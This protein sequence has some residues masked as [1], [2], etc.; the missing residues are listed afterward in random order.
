VFYLGLQ[1]LRW[2]GR[3]AGTHAPGAGSDAS[4]GRD[5]KP[6]SRRAGWGVGRPCSRGRATQTRV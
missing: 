2:G 5:L 3:G 6:A 1:I 4:A